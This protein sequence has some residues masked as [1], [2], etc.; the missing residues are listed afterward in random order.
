MANE[1]ETLQ[2]AL[3]GFFS[4]Q[5]N[6]R[7]VVQWPNVRYGDIPNGESWVRYE[8]LPVDHRFASIGSVGNKVMSRNMGQ[9]I[10]TVFS[11][12]NSGTL[13]SDKLCD[14]VMDIFRGQTVGDAI[15]FQPR[16]QLPVV[17][18]EWYQVQVVC[19]YKH[20]TFH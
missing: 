8:E 5:W 4:T 16:R 17:E 15:F 9:V 6:G 18:N 14:Q 13:E 20:D 1:I 3:Q 12:K 2:T 7:T 19:E 10:I 11:P